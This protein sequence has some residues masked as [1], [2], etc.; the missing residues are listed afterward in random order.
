QKMPPAIHIAGTNGKGSTSNI[1]AKIFQCHNYKVHLYTSPHLHNCNER[2]VINGEIISDAD[3]FLCLEEVRLASA[4]VDLTFMEG[5]TIGAFVAFAKFPADI[6]ILECGMGARID[7]TNIVENKIASIITSISLDHQE[8]LG[9]NLEDIAFEKCFVAKPLTPLIVSPQS[10]NV[11]DIITN[12][13]NQI[14]AQIYHYEDDFFVEKIIDEDNKIN[15]NF[16][17]FWIDELLLP[18]LNAPNLLGDHQ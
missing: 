4:G 11:K 16:N 2:I 12:F 13:A 1:I 15:G 5:F 3:L 8:Y 18:N 14:S 10:K 9:K 6:L 7:I 17:F